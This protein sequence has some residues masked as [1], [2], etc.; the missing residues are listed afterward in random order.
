MVAPLLMLPLMLSG[1]SQAGDALDQ[2]RDLKDKVE[3][4]RW[5]SDV[6][7]LAAAV[8]SANPEAARNLVDALERSAPEDLDAD[9]EV[10]RAAVR[11]IEAGKTRAKDLPSDDVNAATGRLIDAVEQR[12]E[13]EVS[14]QFG[15]S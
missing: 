15:N 14:S 7:R 4:V 8:N 6:V 5:C 13:G 9:V 3:S 11:K 12:C 2:A 1:C 10:V